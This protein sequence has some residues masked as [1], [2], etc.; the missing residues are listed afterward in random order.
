MY[1]KCMEAP[2]NI[3]DLNVINFIAKTNKPTEPKGLANL[4]YNYAF[5]II[6]IYNIIINVDKNHH[7]N[8]DIILYRTPRLKP[9]KEG[10]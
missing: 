5:I 2:I 4:I 9:T 6:L 8:L 1:N 3:E 7:R 10:N